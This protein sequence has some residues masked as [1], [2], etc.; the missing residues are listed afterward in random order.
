QLLRHAYRAI[1]YWHELIEKEFA[2]GT[3]FDIKQF[4]RLPILTRETLRERH[5]EFLI[6][7]LG[8]YK[9]KTF[10]TSGSTGMVKKFVAD[11]TYFQKHSATEEFYVNFFGVKN[12][13]QYGFMLHKPH[14]KD[15]NTQIPSDISVDDL[16]MLFKKKKIKAVGGSVHRL[17]RFAEMMETGKIHVDLKFVVAGSEYLSAD[18]KRYF[19]KIFRCP[20][21]NK[22]VCAE[23]GLMGVECTNRGGFHIDPVGTYLE[24]VD[25][26][27][28]PVV[29]SDLGR[30]V[31]TIFNNRLMPLIRY[32]I[33]DIGGWIEGE[34]ACGLNSPRLFFEG[35]ILHYVE[36]MDGRKFSAVVLIRSL[37]VKFI[38]II[39]KQQVIQESRSKILLKFVP[40][41]AYRPFQRE[42]MHDFIH[43]IL[44]DFPK[45]S[46]E[47]VAV[48]SLDNFKNGKYVI[49][50]SHV[51]KKSHRNTVHSKRQHEQL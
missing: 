17:V 51:K 47:V 46:V 44:R 10:V 45:I 31:I 30:I 20:I 13:W 1:P 42:L 7:H 26:S 4:E 50:E 12:Y 29:G 27:G 2:D 3:V 49:F 25:E 37:D 36:F 40:G 15:L 14:L 8:R 48:P 32:D 35:R 33:G 11:K 24:I 23:A 39:A 28:H 41:H 34:C 22:Y 9:C 38:N 6:E 16:N 18:T 21:Y 5:R 19:E 43:H